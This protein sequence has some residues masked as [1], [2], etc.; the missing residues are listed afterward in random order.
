MDKILRKCLFNNVD[1]GFEI[2]PRTGCIFCFAFNAFSQL[3]RCKNV[4]FIQL[5][6]NMCVCVC[7]KHDN[8]MKYITNIKCAENVSSKAMSHFKC[9]FKGGKRIAVSTTMH[10]KRENTNIIHC[11]S[12]TSSPRSTS[13][14]FS[15]RTFNGSSQFS[16][17]VRVYILLAFDS[18]SHHKITNHPRCT[19]FCLCVCW[20]HVPLSIGN[21]HNDS[22][23]NRKM[24]FVWNA[25]EVRG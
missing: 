15:Y 16:H 18:A 5:N 14:A 3:N 7:S 20:C 12:S 11:R 19:C 10:F 8:H 25:T 23:Y 17:R 21:I 22:N 9:I 24:K 2:R 1:S 13:N 6:S 4:Y